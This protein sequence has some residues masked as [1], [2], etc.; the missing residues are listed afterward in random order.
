MKI[1]TLDD[2]GN[3]IVVHVETPVDCLDAIG[4]WLADSAPEPW[5]EIAIAFTIIAIDDV[6]D[7]CITYKPRGHRRGQ[8]K[9]FFVDDT[10]L[11]ECF[12]ALAKLTGSAENGHFKTCH[13]ILTEDGKYRA[14]YIYE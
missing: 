11:A 10:G 6:S 13:Y 9:Q 2:S 14:D 3:P 8:T 12:F 7:E 4:R 1:R 5:E